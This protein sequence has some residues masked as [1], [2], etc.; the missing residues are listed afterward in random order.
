MYLCSISANKILCL[1]QYWNQSFCVSDLTPIRPTQKGNLTFFCQTI[2]V[3]DVTLY[4]QWS[5]S[6][7]TKRIN[8]SS[9]SSKTR[10]GFSKYYSAYSVQHESQCLFPCFIFR[11]CHNGCRNAKLSTACFLPLHNVFILVSNEIWHINNCTPTCLLPQSVKR[12]IT[13]FY[14]RGDLAVTLLR[15][16]LYLCAVIPILFKSRWGV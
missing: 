12:K 7:L 3:A 4:N 16:V 13:G 5:A 2:T 9:F 8:T 15:K 6:F 10:S 14:G 11:L 1:N